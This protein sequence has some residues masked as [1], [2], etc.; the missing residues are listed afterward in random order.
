MRKIG[1][2]KLLCCASALPSVVRKGV[3]PGGGELVASCFDLQKMAVYLPTTSSPVL[4]CAEDVRAP[5]V[6]EYA[7]LPQAALRDRDY[8]VWAGRALQELDAAEQ[9]SFLSDGAFAPPQ[10]ESF[11]ACYQRTVLWLEALGQDVST[12]V[13]LARPAIVRNLIL[14]VL[15]HSGEPVSIDHAARVD[16]LPGSY[17]LLTR[18]AGR[19]RV[20]MLGA[21]V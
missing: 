11:V 9:L 21:P 2:L 13:V 7:V 14:R 6:G 19:W 20:S 8:G 4:Y 10:G 1:V 5:Q 16:V 15:Y 3:L 12:A 18:H 17:S